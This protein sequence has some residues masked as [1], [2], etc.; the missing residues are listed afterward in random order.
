MN[1]T[2]DIEERLNFVSEVNRKIAET[3]KSELSAAVKEYKDKFGFITHD[4]VN[5]WHGNNTHNHWGW[6]DS[7]LNW[8]LICIG[9]NI[10]ET[11][12]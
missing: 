3:I 12:Q 9:A 10:K 1:I 7:S 5:V 2:D 8:E 4:D 6:D 11:E